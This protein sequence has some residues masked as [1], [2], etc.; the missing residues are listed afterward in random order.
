[1]TRSRLIIEMV[2]L[3]ME[4]YPTKWSAKEISIALNAPL[5]TVTRCLVELTEAKL[6]AKSYNTY[7]LTL[8]LINQFYGAQW[9][10]RQEINK[11][12]KIGDEN[13]K[14]YPANI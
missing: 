2:R 8:E 11:Q 12:I 6:F 3:I 10:I 9:Y 13:G 5:R 1:M 14:H 7:S 4:N